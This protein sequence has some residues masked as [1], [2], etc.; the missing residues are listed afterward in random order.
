MLAAAMLVGPD[1]DGWVRLED[2]RPRVT[3]TRA[4]KT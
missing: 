1:L 2:P 3:G 4:P